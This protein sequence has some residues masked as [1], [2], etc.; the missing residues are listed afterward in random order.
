[1]AVIMYRN[2]HSLLGQTRLSVVYVPDKVR[3]DLEHV[4]A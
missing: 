3:Y 4:K 1:M 2:F